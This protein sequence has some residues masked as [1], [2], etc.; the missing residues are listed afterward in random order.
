MV[1]QHADWACQSLANK[2]EWKHPPNALY[3]NPA[4]VLAN[5]ESIFQ[6]QLFQSGWELPDLHVKI[7]N[8]HNSFTFIPLCQWQIFGPTATFVMKLSASQAVIIEEMVGLKKKKKEIQENIRDSVFYWNKLSKSL[9]VH[10]RAMLHWFIQKYALATFNSWFTQ[11]LLFVI[12]DLMDSRGTIHVNTIIFFLIQFLPVIF[13][14]KQN[15]SLRM[16]IAPDLY[17]RSNDLQIPPRTLNKYAG[18]TCAV[19]WD[20]I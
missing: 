13:P 20:K 14:R 6:K 5:F 12:A 18:S 8:S 15:Q 3:C 4:I 17:Q 16:P 7:G 19:F 9:P 2:Y 1:S 10:Q 11:E